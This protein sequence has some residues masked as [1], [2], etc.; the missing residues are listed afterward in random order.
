MGNTNTSA[1]PDWSEHEVAYPPDSFEYDGAGCMFADD[2]TFI[3]CVHSQPYKNGRIK[4][5]GFGGK[6]EAGENW[7]QTALRE[8]VEEFFHISLASVRDPE[9]FYYDLKRAIAPRTVLFQNKEAFKYLT[10]VFGFAELERFLRVCERY[11]RTSPVY[12]KF[13]TSI[14]DALLGRRSV[15]GTEVFHLIAWPLRFN[16]ALLEFSMDLMVDIRRL[17]GEFIE[18]GVCLISD[19]DVGPAATTT[20]TASEKEP[21]A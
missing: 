13:P 2:S 7:E 21:V 14:E 8:T 3:A 20:T 5:S 16:N 15:A 11:L 17:T 18:K 1:W 9:A 6:R 19:E 12:P 4:I 10:L